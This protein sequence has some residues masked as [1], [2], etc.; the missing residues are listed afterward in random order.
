MSN[1]ETI[2]YKNGKIYTVDACDSQAEAVAIKDGKFVFVGSNKDADAVQADRVIDLE[3]KTVVPGFIEGHGHLSWGAVDA[4]FRIDL[5]GAEKPEDYLEKIRAFVKEHPDLAVYEGFGW[6]NQ[7]FGEQGP[8]RKLL[9]E[10]CDDRPMLFYSGDKHSVWVNT[11]TIETCGVTK[12][13]TVPDGNVIQREEDGYPSGTI[14]EFAAMALVEKILPKY[15]KEDFKKAIRWGVDFL[16]SMGVTAVLDPILDPKEPAIDALHEMEQAGELKIKYRGAF[17]TFE[18]RPNAYLDFMRDTSAAVASHRFRLDQ[19][20]ILT[21]GVVEG[22]TAFLKAPYADDPNYSGYPIWKTEELIEFAKKVDAMGLDLHFHIIG[23]AACAQMLDV[24][25]AVREANP[26][27]T[28]RRPVCTHL[29]V[30][31]RADYPR[32]VDHKV[33]CVTNPYWH[34]KYGGF[35]EGIEKPFLGERAFHEYPM[36]SLL[37]AGAILGAASDF[38]VTPF[39]FALLGIQIGVTRCGWLEDPDNLDLVL[40]PDERASRA[41]LLRAFTMGNAYSMKMDDITGSIEV[42]KCADMTILGADL[43]EVPA[44]DIHKIPI[45]QTISE[46]EV[47]YDNPDGEP[48]SIPDFM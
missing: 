20:K 18:D 14:R 36:K 7:F 28:D 35:F 32:L 30:V 45:L 2:L 46:G 8:S 13:T 42:G 38:N 27:R 39:P 48:V 9:D 17:R 5:F 31:D 21:D 25:D 4:V 23:D 41:D 15:G 40:A 22:K 47:I 19:V 12:E 33:A 43:F 24:L 3:G 26:G 29:Q 10:I 34:F 1:S 16:A 6:D 44:S 11:C 37:D